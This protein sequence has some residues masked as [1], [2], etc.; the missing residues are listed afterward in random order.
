MTVLV[1]AKALPAKAEEGSIQILYLNLRSRSHGNPILVV[2]RLTLLFAM[3][4]FQRKPG[5]SC[6]VKACTVQACKDKSTSVMFH[7]TARTI[8]LRAGR[9]VGTPV[10]AGASVRP[11]P[12]L[13][14]AVQAL[15]AARAG[16]EIVTRSTFSDTLQFFVRARQRAWRDLRSGRTHKPDRKTRDKDERCK[17]SDGAHRRQCRASGLP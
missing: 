1:A 7:M 17:C 6:M 13:G 8:G 15:E 11:A 5:L 2:A 4:A 14:M 9:S 16:S 10:K 3:F 12:Y